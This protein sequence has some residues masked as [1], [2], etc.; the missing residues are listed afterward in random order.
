MGLADVLA[1]DLLLINGTIVTV[2][3]KDSI[4]EAV[5]VKD[6]KVL[7][8]GSNSDVKKLGGEKTKVIDLK[9]KT[10]LPGII[11]S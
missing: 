10:V 9:G 6:G 1:A 2:D 3:A 5:A 11:D 7:S 4:V 8:T